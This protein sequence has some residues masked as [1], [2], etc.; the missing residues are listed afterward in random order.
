VEVDIN[1]LPAKEKNKIIKQRERDTQKA[2]DKEDR[3]AKKG[4][5]VGKSKAM[6]APNFPLLLTE[7]STAT[8]S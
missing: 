2:K 6:A 8:L 1:L 7:A 4:E 3:E 5:R